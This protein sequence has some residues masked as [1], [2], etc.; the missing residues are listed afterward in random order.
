MKIEPTPSPK[1]LAPTPEQVES[2]HT[3]SEK[4]GEPSPTHPPASEVFG[5]LLNLP[6]DVPS[7]ALQKTLCITV[8][9][10]IASTL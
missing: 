8:L 4:V 1:Y 9:S 10:A 5:H 3:L 2:L 7:D 6:H